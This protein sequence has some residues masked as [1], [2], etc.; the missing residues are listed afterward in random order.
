M[1][2]IQE[3]WR[4][5]IVG[6]NK[7]GNTLESHCHSK[8][9]FLFPVSCW[10]E[11]LLTAL[12]VFHVE[13]RDRLGSCLFMSGSGAQGPSLPSTAVSFKGGRLPLEVK[14]KEKIGGGEEMKTKPDPNT[15]IS[16]VKFQDTQ[17]IVTPKKEQQIIHSCSR[18]TLL[19]S[20]PWDSCKVEWKPPHPAPW[21]HKQLA[22]SR[23]A[24]RLTSA[25][26]SLLAVAL[27]APKLTHLT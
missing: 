15:W 27:A 10:L 13:T 26:F 2:Y 8:F 14:L 18:T 22:D 12:D 21:H 6:Q 11:R 9:N 1:K 17:V 5:M 23:H 7:C 16:Y 4:S 25:P 19:Q 3:L 24:L 20:D